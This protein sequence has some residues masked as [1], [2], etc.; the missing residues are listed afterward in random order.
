ME[1]LQ[2]LMAR[3][4][5][6]TCTASLQPVSVYTQ[7]T[8]VCCKA[9][10]KCDSYF[11]YQAVICERYAC[12]VLTQFFSFT[13]FANVKKSFFRLI[14]EYRITTDMDRSIIDL[15]GAVW[16]GNR[17]Q[18]IQV[19]ARPGQQLKMPHQQPAKKSQRPWYHISIALQNM[20]SKSMHLA[21]PYFRPIAPRPQPAS[22]LSSEVHVG[23]IPKCLRQTDLA[24]ISTSSMLLKFAKG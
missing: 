3:C 9:G 18:C 19:E 22:R 2:F 20:R 14:L 7:I 17:R 11:T 6:A 4:S 16:H 8:T 5:G 21:L 10:C 12:K 23:S 24:K 1:L 13:C 15:Q